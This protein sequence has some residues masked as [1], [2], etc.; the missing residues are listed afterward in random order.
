MKKFLKK[1]LRK[2][3]LKYIPLVIF[4]L[5]LSV[6]IYINREFNSA[7]FEQLLY[8]LNSA[9]GT[10]ISAIYEGIIFTIL[11]TIICTLI[12][13]FIFYKAKKKYVLKT[14]IKNKKTAPATS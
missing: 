8:T 4:S 3:N 12:F 7:T 11:L 10:S 9:E 1:I 5:I 2:N 14:K 6:S 13:S